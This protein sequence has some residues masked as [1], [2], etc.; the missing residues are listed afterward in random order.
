M[1]FLIFRLLCMDRPH[2]EQMNREALLTIKETFSIPGS[3][4]GN[5]QTLDSI[6]AFIARMRNNS[7]MADNHCSGVL[8]PDIGVCQLPPSRIFSISQ[9]VGHVTHCNLHTDSYIKL[10]LGPSHCSCQWNSTISKTPSRSA[11]L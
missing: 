5:D 10:V 8:Q 6:L 1:K 11:S 2:L 7:R 4:R 9:M 3:I